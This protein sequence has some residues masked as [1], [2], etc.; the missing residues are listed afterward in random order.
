[1]FR[2]R[3]RTPPSGPDLPG[4]LRVFVCIEVF[5]RSKPVLLVMNDD[6]DR[7]CF[8]CGGGHPDS[9][10]YYRSVGLGHVLDDDPTLRA[11]A[12]LGPG[13]EYERPSVGE[14]WTHQPAP[15]LGSDER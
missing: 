6:D 11:V 5:E 8:L 2:R 12:S 10:E 3:H 13:E 15:P 9:A 14:P 7:R 1:M 4:N